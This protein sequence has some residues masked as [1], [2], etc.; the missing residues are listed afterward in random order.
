MTTIIVN[1]KSDSENLRFDW[2]LEEDGTLIVEGAGRMPDLGAGNHA[3]SLWQDIKDEITKVQIGEGITEVGA[4]N[5]EGC[6][7]LTQVSLPSTLRRIRANAFKN[8]TALREITAEGRS[9]K[10]IR[11]KKADSIKSKPVKDDKDLYFG[12]ETFSNVPWAVEH[13][14]NLYCRDG[15]LY[16]CFAD[17]ESI[18]VPGN[19]HTIAVFAFMNIHAAEL[20]L[21]YSIR[22]IEDYAFLGAS[23]GKIVM[24]QD[25]ATFTAGTYKGSLLESVGYEKGAFMKGKKIKVP[26]LYELAFIKTGYKDNKYSVSDIHKL[27]IREKKGINADGENGALWGR[28]S[29]VVGP[30]LL[31]KLKNGGT[32]IGISVNEEHQIRDVKSMIWCANSDIEK[33]GIRKYTREKSG[34]IRL[35]LMY[36]CIDED[37]GFRYLSIWSD[38]FTDFEESELESAF[39]DR[40]AKKL[41]EM[42]AIREASPGIAEEWFWSAKT[43][44]FGGGIETDLLKQWLKDHPEVSVLSKDE[45]REK[46]NYRWFVSI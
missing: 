6:M 42:G 27:E 24:P 36:P 16:V 10:Y 30:A 9:F 22:C 4:K 39:S 17:Q 21:P 28:N 35:Y 1:D 41:M 13:L 8:C 40:G 46:Q 23:F 14:G 25:R 33:S 18:K 19:V 43:S 31:R 5:F 45:S 15:V 20:I 3:E 38:S 11:E 29:V 7:N 44:G 2:K 37:E 12:T 32:L 34:Y 26:D